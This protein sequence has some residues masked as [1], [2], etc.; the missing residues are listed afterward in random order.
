MTKTTR[1]NL[2][3]SVLLLIVSVWAFIYMVL[4]IKAK[5]ML[6]QEQVIALETKQAQESSYF[7]MQKISEETITERESLASYFFAQESD[8]IDFLNL[9]ESLAPQAGIS[10]QTEGLEQQEDKKKNTSWVIINF[11]FIGAHK[12]VTDF[13]KVLENLPYEAEITNLQLSLQDTGDW[14]AKTTMKINVY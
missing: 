5:N 3:V 4:E 10:L 9:V 7:K 1:R 11:S 6:L 12:N 14:E 2:I 13:I 8:S